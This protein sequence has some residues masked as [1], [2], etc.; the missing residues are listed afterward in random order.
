M[1]AAEVRRER[2]YGSQ[3]SGVS[4]M[5]ELH[6]LRRLQQGPALGYAGKVHHSRGGMAGLWTLISTYTEGPWSAHL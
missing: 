6:V 3:V 2:S 5:T 1:I 4:G